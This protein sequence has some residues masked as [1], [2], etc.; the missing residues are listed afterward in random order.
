VTASQ[1]STAFD[2]AVETLQKIF[3][4][5]PYNDG[6]VIGPRGTDGPSNAL[7]ME[8]LTVIAEGLVDPTPGHVWSSEDRRAGLAALGAFFSVLQVNDTITGAYLKYR[9]PWL[10]ALVNTLVVLKAK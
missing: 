3:R 10:E 1:Q 4:D 8:T 2:Q 5:K 7:Y 6:N 9:R